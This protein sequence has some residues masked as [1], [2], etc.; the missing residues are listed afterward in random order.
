MYEMEYTLPS[1]SRFREDLNF[2]IGED[3]TNAQLSKEKLEEIQ[4]GD[5]KLRENFE[6]NK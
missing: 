6:K 5:R 3:E 2:L 4:R 1:D